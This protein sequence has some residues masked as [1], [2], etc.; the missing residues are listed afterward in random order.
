L[1]RQTQRLAAAAAISGRSLAGRLAITD[2]R[3]IGGRNGRAPNSRRCHRR[4]M[5]RGSIQLNIAI[6][7]EPHMPFSLISTV[8]GV[9]FALV[10]LYVGV[11]MVRLGQMAARQ[12][13]DP[14]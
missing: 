8:L 7:W 4:W 11:M 3:S 1:E 14:R 10:W 9:C 2:Q 5:P 13:K 12:D 6:E